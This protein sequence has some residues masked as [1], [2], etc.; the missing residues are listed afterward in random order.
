PPACRCLALA[1][2]ACLSL[3]PSSTTTGPSSSASSLVFHVSFAVLR[4]AL[5]WLVTSAL[6]RNYRRARAEL[7][8]PVVDLQD[9]EMVELFLRRLK[10]WMGLSRT[11]E[12]RHKVRFEGME[13]P[14]SRSSSTSDC[15]SL[16]LPPLDGS[17]SPLAAW[18]GPLRPPGDPP[19]P[20]PVA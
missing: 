19:L 4:L 3:R 17:E 16:C 13:P 7:Y 9:Y 20:A 6:L 15:Q 1:G 11:K 5:L 2:V 12:F 8:R 18:T 10:M 14:P